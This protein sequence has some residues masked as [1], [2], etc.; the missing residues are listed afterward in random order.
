MTIGDNIVSLKGIS[1]T[2]GEVTAL[3]NVDFF[4]QKSE[5]HGLLGENGAGKST[6]MNILYGLYQPTSGEIYIENKK[7]KIN[8]PHDSIEQGIGMVHQLSTLVPDFNAVENIVMSSRRGKLDLTGEA[9]KIR[10]MASEFGF[11]FPMD[12]KIKELPAGIKQ[13][14][15][16][17][18]SLY[19]GASLLILDEPTTSL[20][21]SEFQQLL[22][23]L[24]YLVEGGVSVIFITHKIRE[25]MAACHAVTVLKKG[26]VQGTLSRE[27]MSKEQLVK[28]MF[29]ERDIEVTESALPKITLPL[30]EK[31][32]DPVYSV[33]GVS[34]QGSE[35]T[36]GL[37]NVSFDIYGGEIFGI[38]SVTGNGE[39]DL[40]FCLTNP[41][42]IDDGDLV[43]FNKSLKKYDTLSLLSE[44]VFYTPADRVKEGILPDASIRENILLGHHSEKR[45]CRKNLFIDWNETRKAA[46][47]VIRDFSVATP[48]EDLQVRR[49]SGGNIQ[50]VIIGRALLSPINLIIMHN[51]TAGLD[52]ASV[53]FVFQQ[54]IKVRS[55]G[56]AVIYINED[57]DEL[58]LLSDRIG[59]LYQGELRGIFARE[60]FDKYQIGMLMIG[61]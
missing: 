51:P 46:R 25:V 33:K 26:R 58:M 16:I 43:L 57:L 22:K 45:F 17:V 35:K 2:F 44:G 4:M 59:V 39:K 6:L 55:E 18:R 8:S 28:L 1:K 5:I 29:L 48:D 20:V 60:E 13:K 19:Q 31:S 15:E 7:V 42:V 23:S 9:K 53:E 38:A 11:T 41:A 10:T 37:K 47:Q 52:I 61:G 14:I 24:Q 27:E 12:V 34:V 36:S 3:D 30:Q 40:A 50:R 54:M 56:N 32:A 49:L 21:E